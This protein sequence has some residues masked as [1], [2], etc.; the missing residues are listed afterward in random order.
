MLGD[1]L[2]TY[3][4]QVGDRYLLEHAPAEIEGL[5]Y[6]T[7]FRQGL[8]DEFFLEAASELQIHAV[9]AG[10]FIL[11]DYCRQHPDASGIRVGAV[12][13]VRQVRVVA[14]RPSLSNAVTHQ[15][16]QRGQDI[17]RRI[18]SSAI[19]I[20]LQDNLALG[21]VSGQVRNRM[22][23]VVIGHGENRDLSYRAGLALDSS[24]ALIERRQITVEVAG[25]ALAARDLTLG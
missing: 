5:V 13:L 12:K 19:E 16:G 24:G 9:A 15:A 6:G 10:E 17:Y 11:T 23:Y 25:I 14:A 3:S 4:G 7:I 8:A 20:T 21:D 18:D 22:G 2:L 1:F